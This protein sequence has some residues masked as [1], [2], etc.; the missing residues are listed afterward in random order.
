MDSPARPAPHRTNISA[1]PACNSTR[2]LQGL[3][4]S[5]PAPD[6]HA[7]SPFLKQAWPAVSRAH[8]SHQELPEPQMPSPLMASLAL[9]TRLPPLTPRESQQRNFRSAMARSHCLQDTAGTPSPHPAAPVQMCQPLLSAVTMD[10]AL[11]GQRTA[12]SE[13][14]RAEGSAPSPSSRNSRQQ[15]SSEFP[16]VSD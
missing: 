8:P 9:T 2:S 12:C 13:L 10:R 11:A 6:S 4:S 15:L 16:G 14:L 3:P 7:L 5:P 1:E